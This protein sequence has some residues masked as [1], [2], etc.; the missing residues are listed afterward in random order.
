MRSLRSSARWSASSYGLLRRREIIIR[1]CLVHEH[2][3]QGLH[4]MLGNQEV[5]SENCG[6]KESRVVSGSAAMFRPTTVLH[7]T[8]A[9]ARCCPPNEGE[10]IL[11]SIRNASRLELFTNQWPI[12]Q[13]LYVSKYYHDVDLE[14]VIVLHIVSTPKK[15]QINPPDLMSQAE[16]IPVEH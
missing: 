9:P 6:K 4:P 11:L 10:I 2:G 1:I 7:S 15:R 8:R 3:Q 5:C 12:G 14:A 13:S 16:H